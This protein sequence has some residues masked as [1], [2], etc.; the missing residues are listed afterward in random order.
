[1][2]V[3]RLTH[4]AGLVA[5]RPELAVY[6]PLA[7]ATTA[8]GTV[9]N[10]AVQRIPKLALVPALMAGAAW[11]RRLS[12]TL[13]V[14]GLGATAGDW[15]M[16]RSGE[17][18]DQDPARS[19]RY[20]RLGAAAFAVQ[21]L[22]YG[23]LLVRRGARLRVAPVLRSVAVLGALAVLEGRGEE[24]G[25]LPDPVLAAYGLSLGTMAALTAG[26]PSRDAG[27]DPLVA[28]GGA[29]FLASDALIIVRQ[30]VSH[31]VAR[32]ALEAAVL[33]T[34]TIAQAILVHELES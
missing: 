33:G 4:L 34:Y 12:A 3:P 23:V 29:L 10:L 28:T 19:R 18:E 26:T 27:R 14:A 22:G 16:L 11:R 32:A 8:T 13:A 7:I 31:R 2:R 9:G 21:Q 24:G 30:Q 17:T 5:Q 25:G 6:A 15:W 1:M 20:L